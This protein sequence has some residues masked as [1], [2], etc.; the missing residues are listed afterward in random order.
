M[1]QLEKVF[2]TVKRSKGF[3][4]DGNTD[5]F[6]KIGLPVNT[7]SL[8]DIFDLSIATGVF[9]DIAGKFLELPPFTKVVTLTIDLLVDRFQYFFL[10][11][12]FSKSWFTINFFFQ[13][14]ERNF[15]FPSSLDLDLCTL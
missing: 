8:C 3:G 5:Y 10:L 15:F 11:P 2:G 6:L 1:C 14:T 7:E 13:K 4:V 9:P 12:E